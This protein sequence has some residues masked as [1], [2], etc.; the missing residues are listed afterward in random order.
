MYIHEISK[1]VHSVHNDISPVIFKDYFI[2]VTDYR[3]A[4]P[5]RPFHHY[6]YVLPKPRT[7]KG[8]HSSIFA[9]VKLWSK[10]PQNFK[11]LS[12]KNFSYQ[13]K[14]HIFDNGLELEHSLDT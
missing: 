10:I 4:R 3:S 6:D 13:L 12:K 11:R 5:S 1:F 9:G 2:P 8:K 14:Q 7:E